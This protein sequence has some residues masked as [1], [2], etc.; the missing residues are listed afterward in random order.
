MDEGTPA[1][2]GVDSRGLRQRK[3]KNRGSEL[4]LEG[5]TFFGFY[6]PPKSA[7]RSIPDRPGNPAVAGSAH[8]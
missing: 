7:T 4:D 1:A 6:D 2:L 8:I 3:R 5:Q